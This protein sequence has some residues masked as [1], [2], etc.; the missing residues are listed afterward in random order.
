M[1]NKSDKLPNPV[2]YSL[3]LLNYGN[4]S[5]KQMFEAL[6]KRGFTEETA[7][8]TVESLIEWGYLDDAKYKEQLIDKRKRNNVKGRS[9]VYREL[10]NAGIDDLEDLDDLY[11]DEEE[12][13]RIDKLLDQWERKA[14]LSRENQDKYFMRLARRGFAKGNI[15]FCMEKRRN[16]IEIF[17]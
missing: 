10:N 17:S 7:N 2:N 3:W 1:K 15:F 6:L 5:V 11:D 14:P 13:E 16:D 4:K 12:K 8:E 9:F